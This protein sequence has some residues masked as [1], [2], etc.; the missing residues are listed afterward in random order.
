MSY[1]AIPSDN[2][3][4]YQRIKALLPEHLQPVADRTREEIRVRNAISVLGQASRTGFFSQDENREALCLHKDTLN[5]IARRLPAVERCS[6]AIPFKAAQEIF[7]EA[8]D[9]KTDTLAP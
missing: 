4:E 2:E 7:Y 9:I 8:A 6:D 1:I 3:E 5:A